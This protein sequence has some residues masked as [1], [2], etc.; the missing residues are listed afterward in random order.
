ME[1]RLSMKNLQDKWWSYGSLKKNQYGNLQVSFKLTALI[2]LA[3]VAETQGK[4][5]VNLSCFEVD[6]KQKKHS[7][8]KANAYVKQEELSDSIPF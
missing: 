5:W 3:K 2:E 8:A 7:V 4:E 1:Y 6:D